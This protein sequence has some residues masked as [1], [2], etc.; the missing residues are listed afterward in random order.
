MKSKQITVDDIWKLPFGTQ[1]LFSDEQIKSID[2][3]AEGG[4]YTYCNRD[5]ELGEL[6]VDGYGE[7]FWSAGEIMD[8]T[9]TVYQVDALDLVRGY[10]KGLVAYNLSLQDEPIMHAETIK[11]TEVNIQNMRAL[12][13]LLDQDQQFD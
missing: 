7:L 4:I 2:D 9:V 5:Q 13:D 8:Q 11:F 10:I 3:E 12:E 6:F 1:V